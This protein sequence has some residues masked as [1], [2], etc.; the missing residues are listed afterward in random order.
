V[1][2]CGV[3]GAVAVAGRREAPN[4][5]VLPAVVGAIAGGSASAVAPEAEGTALRPNW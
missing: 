2:R 3:A 5:M 1:V 4:I